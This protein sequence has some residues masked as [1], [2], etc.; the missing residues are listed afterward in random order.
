[1]TVNDEVVGMAFNVFF[2]HLP[3]RT[4]ENYKNLRQESSPQAEIRTQN[5]PNK[6][7]IQKRCLIKN[8]QGDQGQGG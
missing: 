4:E 8:Y 6:I 5:L 3:G 1:M 2:Q 7:R